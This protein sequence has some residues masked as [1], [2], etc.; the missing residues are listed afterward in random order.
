ML[1][2]SV[3]P[4]PMEGTGREKPS[5]SNGGMRPRTTKVSR[6]ITV[7]IPFFIGKCKNTEVGKNA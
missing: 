3:F 5:Q 1:N 6:R 7:F 4:S 2:I